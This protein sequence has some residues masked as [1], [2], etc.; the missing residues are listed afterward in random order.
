ME[1]EREEFVIDAL[2]KGVSTIAAGIPV[3]LAVFIA[4]CFSCYVLPVLS[5]ALLVE[6]TFT[7]DGVITHGQRGTNRPPAG[8]RGYGL[9]VKGP[10]LVW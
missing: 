3:L 10:N 8:E 2:G 7:R 4:G 1:R 9:W 5:C 6:P